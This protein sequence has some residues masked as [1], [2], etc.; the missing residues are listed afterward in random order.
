VVEKMLALE[1][2][3]LFVVDSDGVLIGVISGVDVLRN[4]RRWGPSDLLA[5]SRR[6]AGG[7]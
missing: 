1:V 6:D 7:R 2:R 4:L 3:R 5:V